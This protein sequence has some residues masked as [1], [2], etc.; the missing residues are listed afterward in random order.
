MDHLEAA[1][2]PIVADRGGDVRI[3][4]REQRI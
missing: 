2:V 3:F 1:P 4:F